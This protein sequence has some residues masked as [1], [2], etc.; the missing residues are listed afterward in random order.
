[1]YMWILIAV[2]LLSVLLLILIAPSAHCRR[3]DD[4]RGTVFA[5]RGLYGNGIAE[6]TLDAFENA[7]KNGFGIELDVQ[8]SH[9]GEIVVFHDDDLK[10]MTGDVRRVDAVNFEELAAL[11]LCGGKGTIPRFEE[12]LKLVNGRVPILVELKN[13]RKNADLCE[14]T[15]AMLKSYRGK[16]L[17]ESFN[18]LILKWFRQNEPEMLRG[19]LVGKWTSYLTTLGRPGAFVLSSLILNALSRSD[20]VA[21][22]V[23][24]RHFA[25]P[26]V[27]RALFHTPL[28]AWTVRDEKTYSECL[29][30]GEM[31]IFESF[32][33]E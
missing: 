4:W 16:Y 30:R 19:Q 8:F 31:P 26:H 21:Y 13:G 2:L 14:K 20:F 22:D 24:A 18:P 25:A 5:H 3:A 6:N 32:I 28:A 7:C 10:R 17:V 11:S 29:K 9:D 1:M 23:N 27:Q 33:P 15:S 12:V